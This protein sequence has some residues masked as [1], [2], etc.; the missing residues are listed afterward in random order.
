MV[1]LDFSTSF[2]VEQTP[3]EAFNA[4]N[5]VRGWWSE[6]IEGCTDK[7]NEEFSY[8]YEDV[9]RS[10]MKIIELIPDQKVVWQVVDNYFKFTQ[11]TTEWTGNEIIFDISKQGDK[12][13][14][15]M[16]Q[17]GLTPQYECYNICSDAWA[18]YMQ[19][20]LHD[21]ITTGQGKPNGKGKPQTENEKKLPIK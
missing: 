14:I 19:K 4:I 11:D 12:T 13:E 16:T 10:T 17:Q 8:H 2:V 9:H 15:K 3:A 21:L 7:L 6:E 20:S 1:T 18:N 5:N